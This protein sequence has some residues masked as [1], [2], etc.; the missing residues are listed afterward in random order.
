[1]TPKNTIVTYAFLVGL[2][3][4]QDLFDSAFYKNSSNQ[5]ET[6][7]LGIQGR[8][9]VD[10]ETMVILRD[11]YIH[12]KHKVSDVRFGFLLSACFP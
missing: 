9:R 6:F 7:P 10:N 11:R 2:Q 5:T 8:D 1:M 4:W 3:R 12:W